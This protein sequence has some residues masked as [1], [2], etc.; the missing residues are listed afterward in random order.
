MKLLLDEMHSPRVAAALR[1]R[2]HDVVAVAAD[3][4]LRGVDDADLL[5]VAATDG[6]VLVTENVGDLTAIAAA[7]K[8]AGR[9]HPGILLL[10]SRRRFPA[11]D[12]A[13]LVGA[14]EHVLADG[15]ASLAGRTTRLRVPR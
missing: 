13:G 6:R 15:G 10:T 8:A 7:W 5:E 14:L 2:G 11:A 4:D 1:R 9:P 3:P 12:I